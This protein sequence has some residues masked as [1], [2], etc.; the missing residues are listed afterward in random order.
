[1]CQDRWQFFNTSCFKNA[2]TEIELGIKPYICK[3]TSGA[4][5][6]LELISKFFYKS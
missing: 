1:M 3:Y 4:W 6:I 5:K 2:G